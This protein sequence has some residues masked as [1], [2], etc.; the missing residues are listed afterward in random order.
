MQLR[1]GLLVSA[2]ALYL[3]MFWWAVPS[4]QRVNGVST[5]TLGPTSASTLDTGQGANELYDMDQNV[6]TTSSPVFSAVS[7]G[8]N[9]VAL[10][11]DGDGAIILTGLGDGSDENLSINL[12]DI[13]N[14]VAVASSTGVNSLFLSGIALSANGLFLGTVEMVSSGTPAVSSCGDGALATGSTDSVG[15]VNATN[16]TAC[17]ITFSNAL[18]TN[19]ASCIVEN[20]TANRGNVSAVST[21]AF[22]VSNLTAGDDF[23]YICMGR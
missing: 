12:D 19:G 20:V 5:P 2:V 17:T 9:G 7:L 1:R 6:L 22:T 23:D 14:T 3:A 10:S 15:R 21:T 16:A 13:A 18:G 8:T 4:A 11:H